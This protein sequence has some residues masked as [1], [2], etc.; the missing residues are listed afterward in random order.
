MDKGMRNPREFEACLR[1]IGESLNPFTVVGSG[2]QHR[3]ADESTSGRLD[4]LV[5]R[6]SRPI[7]MLRPENATA[8]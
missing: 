3:R 8:R 5:I 4:L 2:N 7:W 6:D 1:C